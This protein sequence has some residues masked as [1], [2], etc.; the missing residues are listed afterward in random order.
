MQSAISTKQT[1]FVSIFPSGRMVVTAPNG[2]TV[3]T[4]MEYQELSA[5]VIE[6]IPEATLKTFDW[7]ELLVDSI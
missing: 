2:R 3:P 5:K 1:L 7:R 6:D 4:S